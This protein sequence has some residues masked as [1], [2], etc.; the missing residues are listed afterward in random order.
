MNTIYEIYKIKLNSAMKYEDYGSLSKNVGYLP[1]SIT[2]K[3]INDEIENKRRLRYEVLKKFYDDTTNKLLSN[4]ITGFKMIIDSRKIFV[5]DFL[6]FKLE[7]NDFVAY[8]KISAT[9]ILE[10]S[11]ND[12]INKCLEIIFPYIKGLYQVKK[13]SNLLDNSFYDLLYV[14]LMGCFKQIFT[15]SGDGVNIVKNPELNK[16]EYEELNRFLETY[17]TKI[18]NNIKIFDNEALEPYRTDLTK[19][20]VLSIYK[21][22]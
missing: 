4:K 22:G 18:L 10:N 21:R 8:P 6:N 19:R 20:K 16:N 1:G 7:K 3:K 2:L 12:S 5:D 15:I 11:Y 13:E 9:N 17:K 14:K